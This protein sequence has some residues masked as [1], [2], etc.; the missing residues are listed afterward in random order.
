ML[1]YFPFGESFDARMGG[2][3]LNAGDPLCEVDL[4]NYIPQVQLKRRMLA[5]N[6]ADY[7]QGGSDMLAQQ[8]EALALVLTNLAAI[9]PDCFRLET[10]GANWLWENHLLGER[11]QFRLGETGSLPFEPLDWTG[12]QVQEDLVLLD[13][14]GDHRL[15][16]GQLCFANSWSLA[17]HLGRAFL[18]IH[19]PTPQ[20]TMPSVHAGKRLLETLKPGKAIWRLNWNFKLSDRLDLSTRQQADYEAEI[21]ARAPQMTPDRVGK[22]MFLRVERQTLTRLPATMAVLFGIHTYIA[23]LEDEAAD[24]QRA[25]RILSVIQTAP[26]DV[27][28]YKA[29]TLVESALKAYLQSRL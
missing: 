22:E 14:D 20:T 1:R 2:H 17:S 16:G 26:Q 21:L 3:P 23:R 25:R 27:K 19:T 9:Q 8:W 24:P 18:E 7:F 15:I 29:I 28:D 5:E 11:W 12:R 10:D 13:P 4:P 6:H